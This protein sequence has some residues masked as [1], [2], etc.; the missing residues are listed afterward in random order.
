MSINFEVNPVNL[1]SG[2]L[3]FKRKVFGNFSS[4]YKKKSYLKSPLNRLNFNKQ[5]IPFWYS[6]FTVS[7][8]DIRTKTNFKFNLDI[9][10]LLQVDPQFDIISYFIMWDSFFDVSGLSLDFV[11]H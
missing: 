9:E 11:R 2:N 3:F 1:T 8:H 7:F 6:S 4:S 5:A 10:K